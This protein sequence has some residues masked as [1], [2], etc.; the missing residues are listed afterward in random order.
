M[1][2][3]SIY[4]WASTI[5][6]HINCIMVIVS[7]MVLAP[8]IPYWVA[9]M[10][11]WEFLYCLLSY[12]RK[13]SY[14]VN[15]RIFVCAFCIRKKNYKIYMNHDLE[16]GQLASPVQ[17]FCQIFEGPIHVYIYILIDF[18]LVAQLRQKLERLINLERSPCCAVDHTHW[19]AT[20]AWSGIALVCKI[21]TLFSR[22]FGQIL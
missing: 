6:S 8:H 9:S 5:F 15:F 13:F 1:Y 14:G 16:Y 11:R 2:I 3:R 4:C 22:L 19:W 17:V 12:S 18:W 10:K 7:Y 21:K 20:W